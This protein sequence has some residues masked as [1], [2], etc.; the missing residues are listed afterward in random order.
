MRATVYGEMESPIGRL[1]VISDGA[2]LTGLLMERGSREP[3]TGGAV[4]DDA[5]PVVAE[6]MRQLAAYFAGALTEFDVPIAARGTPFQER[7]WSALR[8]IPFGET[9][10]Y[11]EIARRIGR[12]SAVRAVGAANGRNP[13]AIVVPCHR[14]IGADG[15]LIGYGGGMD[16]KRWLLA[17]E[18]RVRSRAGV[19]R[20]EAQALDLFASA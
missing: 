11:A 6:T 12:P 15:S 7:V 10:A 5:A 13:V 17:H 2:A 18:E 9:V 3:A 4:R 14:V 16:R 20:R 1:T 19:A 8:A